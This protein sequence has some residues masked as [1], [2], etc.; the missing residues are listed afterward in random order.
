MN[1]HSLF[2][3]VWIVGWHLSGLPFVLF[4]RKTCGIF[5][6][7]SITSVVST[8]FL[9]SVS[10]RLA[11]S[12]AISRSYV[13]LSKPSQRSVRKTPSCFLW[14]RKVFH[15]SIAKKEKCYA[16]WPDINAHFVFIKQIVLKTCRD[17]SIFF[18]IYT[19]NIWQGTYWS[20][21]LIGSVVFFKDGLYY[22]CIFIFFVPRWFYLCL[23]FYW[24]KVVLK[25]FI[26]CYCV[27]FSYL[28]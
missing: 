19:E 6:I 18:H 26:S 11:F 3:V 22:H 10:E 21:I 28:D 25:N 27:V 1:I 16:I 13:K 8:R 9:E 17:L 5:S 14:S 2:V 4:N 15:F 12:L 23:Q 20:I 7:F 24:R